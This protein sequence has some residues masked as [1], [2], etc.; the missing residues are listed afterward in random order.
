MDRVWIVYLTEKKDSSSVQLDTSEPVERLLRSYGQARMQ[1]ISF[2]ARV[3]QKGK[4][5]WGYFGK[6]RSVPRSSTWR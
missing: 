3:K 6:K 2:E 5:I 1:C 4:R